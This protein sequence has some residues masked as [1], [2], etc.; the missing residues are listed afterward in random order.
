MATI[1]GMTDPLPAVE[2]RDVSASYAERGRRLQ[3]LDGLSLVV[4]PGELVAL[5]GPSGS[6]KSTLL[7]VVAG[8]IEPDAG[9]VLIAGVAWTAAERLGM[10]A[11]MRQ[12]DLLLPWRT[13]GAN[14]ALALEAAGVG[15]REA[16]RRAS[17]Q[18]DRLGLASFVD[19][20]PAQLSGGMRQRVAFARTMLAG[21]PVLLLDEPFGAIDALTR[22]ELHA[23]L[24]ATLQ[25]DPRTTLLVTH[26]VEEA[27]TLADR[28]VV[29]TDR[30]ARVTHVEPILLLRPRPADITTYPQAIQHKTR[31]LAALGQTALAAS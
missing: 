9:E 26:D 27:I 16:R 30:P 10:S 8:L 11:Y 21:R 29:L 2:I 17:G 12:R 22:A 5:I 6:G 13:V 15:R 20:Y 3:V 28:V 25:G 14:A 24:Q 23:G 31:I 7:D 19:A 18:L 4:G 1:A